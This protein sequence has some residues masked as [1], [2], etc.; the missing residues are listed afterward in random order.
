MILCRTLCNLIFKSLLIFFYFIFNM[1][2]MQKKKSIDKCSIKLQ[3]ALFFSKNNPKKIGGVP[4][5]GDIRWLTPVQGAPKCFPNWARI[6][7][8]CLCPADHSASTIIKFHKIPLNGPRA[9][10]TLDSALDPETSSFLQVHPP[11]Q[12]PWTK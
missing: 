1:Y 3:G 11:C 8:C 5:V 6:L 9:K 4:S 12:L 7:F 2:V 10:F